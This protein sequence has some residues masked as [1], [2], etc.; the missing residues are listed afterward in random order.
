MNN[1]KMGTVQKIVES[2]MRIS[3]DKKTQLTARYT[4]HSSWMSSE[5]ALIREL[6]KQSPRDQHKT[7]DNNI[8]DENDEV[9]IYH[10]KDTWVYV[11]SFTYSYK[12]VL[13][14]SV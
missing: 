10:G 3:D 12:K 13:Q 4:E 1:N 11:Y 8:S 7:I 9:Y 6:I 5:L 14:R 2:L